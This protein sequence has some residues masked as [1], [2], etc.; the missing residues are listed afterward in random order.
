MSE[1]KTYDLIIIGAGPA[2][3]SA[4]L[5]SIRYK[6]NTLIIGKSIGGT[7]L[8]CS[9]ISNYPGQEALSG[10]E[11]AKIFINRVKND[12]SIVEEEATAIFKEKENFLITTKKNQF[13]S[14]ALIF[15]SGAVRKK[16][17]VKGEEEFKN[18][19]VSYCAICD[20]PLFLNKEVVVVGS[21][22]AALHAG[23]LLSE[24]ANKVYILARAKFKADPILIDRVLENQKIQMVENI[25]IEEIQ[26][27]VFVEKVLLNNKVNGEKYLNVQ[28]VFAE[29]GIEPDTSIL[30]DLNI[31]TDSVGF[32][33]TDEAMETNI[34]GFYAAGDI[35][36]GSNGLR[37]V[38][39]GA[40]EGAVAAT[41][42][43]HKI[44][45]QMK[46]SED[47]EFF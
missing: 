40:A 27:N 3:L 46:E 2:G 42:V 11:F 8:S 45:E 31:K 37:Q 39:T 47:K 26:G 25:S 30:K 28:G 6:L 33:S 36:T 17:K 14:K 21:G 22:N 38:I 35:T 43:Y 16:L 12:I 32:I 5:Y 18:K 15:A 7:L 41:S 44:K 20:S 4:G 19:G 13:K 23:I 1:E 10:Q 34:P 29:I 9:D 24:H